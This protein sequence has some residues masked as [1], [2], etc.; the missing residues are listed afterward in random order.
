MMGIWDDGESEQGEGETTELVAEQGI[1][2]KIIM[3]AS[4][5]MTRWPN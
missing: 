1:N 5:L 4:A 2:W 3:V